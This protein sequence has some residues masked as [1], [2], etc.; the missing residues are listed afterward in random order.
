MKY[1]AFKKVYR[2]A[3]LSVERKST[4]N[5]EKAVYVQYRYITSKWFDRY[6]PRI[7]KEKSV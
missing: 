6:W 5:V 2:K 1:R 4:Q 7:I 3:K